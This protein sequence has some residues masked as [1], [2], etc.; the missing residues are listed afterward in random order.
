MSSSA[1]LIAI[2]IKAVGAID[3]LKDDGLTTHRLECTHWR[4]HA[5]GQQRLRLSKNLQTPGI[6][7]RLEHK[8]LDCV[9]RTINFSRRCLSALLLAP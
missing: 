8:L 9:D 7:A 2:H 4:I 1:H 5:A 3:A 6:H